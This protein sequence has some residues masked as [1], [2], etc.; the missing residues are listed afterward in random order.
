MISVNDQV[1]HRRPTRS[2][3]LIEI[4]EVVSI[5]AD[6]MTASV[7]FP[8]LYKRLELPVDS[9]ERTADRF[10]VQRVQSHPLR[11]TMTYRP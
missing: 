4:G 10:G 11:R 7:N 8:T 5:S 3:T 1:I 6:G 2:G 9:L